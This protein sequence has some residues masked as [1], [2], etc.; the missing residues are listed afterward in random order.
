MNFN[1]AIDG[2]AGAGK[3]TVA[4]IVADTLNMTYIDT[5]AMYRAITLLSIRHN[6]SDIN[7]IVELI[8]QIEIK[9]EGKRVYIDNED[10]SDD[11]RSIE[12]TNEVSRIAKIPEIRH[13]MIQLQR[14]MAK[15]KGVVMDGRDIGTIVL[16]DAKYKFFLTADVRERAI[17]RYREMIRK[18]HDVTLEQVEKDIEYRDF[19]DKNRDY[20]P[21]KAAE[22][23]VI[24]DTTN[25]TI[26]QVVEEIIDV[27]KRGEG[28]VL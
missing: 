22:D 2:P 16:P 4:K 10:V 11:I 3:S 7:D 5:G 24:I 15:N 19:Q 23:A 14:E 25:K 8:K 26:Q 1:I 20:S 6:K 12:V 18:G 13:V 21:L 27:I 9:I 17:R 28:I